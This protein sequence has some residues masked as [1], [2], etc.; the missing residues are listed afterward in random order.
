MQL[1]KQ[2]R[3]EIGSSC[4]QRNDS[5]RIRIEFKENPGNKMMSEDGFNH[6]RTYTENKVVSCVKL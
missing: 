4:R 6:M 3:F 2:H 5:Y 1:F